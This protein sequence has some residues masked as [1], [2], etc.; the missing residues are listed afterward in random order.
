MYFHGYFQTDVLINFFTLLWQAE[1]IT[2][3]NFVLAKQDLGSTIKGSCL[4]R[5]HFLHVIAKFNLYTAYDVSLWEKR[6]NNRSSLMMIHLNVYPWESEK[7]ALAFVVQVW[8]FTCV[9]L[10][11]SHVVPIVFYCSYCFTVYV[12][13][14]AGC[15]LYWNNLHFPTSNAHPEFSLGQLTIT[16]SLIIQ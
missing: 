10:L 15:R 13:G 1:A 14:I 6:V 8:E 12:L 3:E 9:L 11:F 4:A 7:W 5:W 2:W 16:D